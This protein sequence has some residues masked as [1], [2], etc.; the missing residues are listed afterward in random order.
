MTAALPGL[1][2]L[3]WVDRQR[4]LWLVMDHEAEWRKHHANPDYFIIPSDERERMFNKRFDALF[5]ASRLFDRQLS[6]DYARGQAAA[7]SMSFLAQLAHDEYLTA[8][9]DLAPVDWIAGDG[10]K[11]FALPAVVSSRDVDGDQVK[12]WRGTSLPEAVRIDVEALK[13]RAH[14][15]RTIIPTLCRYQ[16]VSHAK[17]RLRQC[18]RALRESHTTAT[19]PG[20]LPHHYRE[21]STGRFAALGLNGQSMAREVR[22][23]ALQGYFDY[24]IKNCHF[25]IVAQICRR[26]GI[27]HPLIEAY[28]DD[29][30]RYRQPL[31]E[32]YALDDDE[33]KKCILAVLYGATDSL[34]YRSAIPSLIGVA[35]ARQL[36]A[37]HWFSALSDE[38]ERIMLA[39]IDAWPLGAG[40]LIV[41]EARK[42]ID[43]KE[44]APKIF[45]H[46]LQGVEGKMLRAVCGAYP[47]DIVVPV[48]DGFISRSQLNVRQIEHVIK[49][50]TGYDMR[51]SESVLK[52]TPVGDHYKV[53]L[54][55]KSTNTP[56]LLGRSA[57]VDLWWRNKDLGDSGVVELWGC[58][59]AGALP[60]GSG[61]TLRKLREASASLMQG[62]SA[63]V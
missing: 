53:D 11:A 2:D 32:R 46:L 58:P 36:L 59:V 7:F 43:P 20:F 38:V 48:H 51:I 21:V 34:Y 35:E 47:D 5:D 61:V 55:S 6:Y 12:L 23:V 49:A 17:R 60:V 45:A 44:K 29:K 1:R 57:G 18:V 22:A 33:V 26:L 56:E 14:E 16:D 50:A 40:G 3:A 15:Y 24:D 30:D 62:R 42:G 41:N 27:P 13:E 8:T 39:V 28:S 10:K 63:V 9:P 37:D 25:S 4:L 31:C 52:P 19:A 54:P